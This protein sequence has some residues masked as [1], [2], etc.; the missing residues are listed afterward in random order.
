ME[1]KICVSCKEEKST[2]SFSKNRNEKD[3][4]KRYC[5]Q[6]ASEQNKRYRERHREK[7][8]KANKEWYWNSKKKREQRTKKAL[9]EGSKVCSYC[10]ENK[11]MTEY[12]ERGN[13]GFYGECKECHNLKMKEYVSENRELVLERKRQ[14]YIRTRE[15]HL[16]YFRQYNR[17]NS[18]RNVERAKRWAGNNPERAKE[19]AV[20]SHHLR[21][22]KMKGLK[23]DFTRKE[24]KDCKDYFRND[25]GLIECAYCSKEMKKATK[26]HFVPV[27]KGGDYTVGNILPVCL[28]CNS[29]K[30]ATDFE[31]WYPNTE[32]FSR[33][34][35]ERIY[36]Y[37]EHVGSKHANT[38]PSLDGN[39]R[40]V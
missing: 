16:E 5:K 29:R 20:R 11:L 40:K 26:D 4:L 27:H 6:C 18:E 14:Y 28:N 3:G 1:T 10:G 17:E 30:S 36:S 7:K 25:K 9:E 19:L 22:A 24:W 23:H 12:Y 13:G 33:N 15:Q 38:V 37:F 2:A 39:T 21:T 32:F 31:D 8:N 34:N 35:V